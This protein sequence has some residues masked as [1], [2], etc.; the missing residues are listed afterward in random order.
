MM[1]IWTVCS[2][3]DGRRTCAQCFRQLDAKAVVHVPQEYFWGRREGRKSTA[4][5]FFHGQVR[6]CHKNRCTHGGSVNLP[7]RDILKS[8]VRV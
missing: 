8:E 6:N 5:D 1:K 2:I 4:F 7:E 3:H